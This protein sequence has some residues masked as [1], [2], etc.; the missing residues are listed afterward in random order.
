MR[1]LFILICLVCS[2]IATQLI[3]PLIGNSEEIISILITVITV[4]AGFLV[5]IVTILGDPS[6]IPRG[7]WRV[8][9][10]KREKYE[11]SIKRH[12]LIFI[13]YLV[14]I[15]GLFVGAVVHGSGKD[16]VSDEIKGRIQ[17]IYLFLSVFSFF[18]TF[19]LP[20]GLGR[21]QIERIDAEIERR[22]DAIRNVADE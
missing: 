22:R 12:Q 10:N 11:L 7:S 19:S 9:E 20:F 14:A 2:F 3:C 4:F 15:A 13:V 21:L 18:L 1:I 17:K 6:S 16:V 5:A 8:A